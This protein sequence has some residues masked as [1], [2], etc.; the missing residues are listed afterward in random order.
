MSGVEFKVAAVSSNRNSFG[1]KGVVLIARGGRA[2]QVGA[3]D[4]HVPKVG[5][6]ITIPFIELEGK[7]VLNFAALCFEIPEELNPPAPP[8]VVKEVWGR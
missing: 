1:L 7:P 4:L 3:S 5:D 6:V 2:F 8:S